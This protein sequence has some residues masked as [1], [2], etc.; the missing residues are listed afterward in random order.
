M[1]FFI[2]ILIAGFGGGAVRGLVGFLKKESSYSYKNPSFNIPYFFLMAF[3]SAVVG[4]LTAIAVKESA[5][6]IEG[7]SFI[8]PAIAFIIGYAGGDF[9]EGLYKVI[10]KRIK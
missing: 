10:L 3:I 5:I 2:S 6:T 8:S 7:I 9:L 1:N 4:L